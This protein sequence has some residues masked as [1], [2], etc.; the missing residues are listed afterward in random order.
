MIIADSG[1]VVLGALDFGEVAPG[2]EDVARVY[3][4]VPPAPEARQVEVQWTQIVPEQ[5]PT[6]DST[7]IPL[8][9]YY[10][11]GGSIPYL[12]YTCCIVAGDID[13]NGTL[14]I[15]DAVFRINWTFKGGPAPACCDAADANYN[16]AVG[17]DDAVYIINHIFKGGPG[18]V[19]GSAGSGPCPP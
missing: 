8:I 7:V 16:G 9:A 10:C 5:S 18:P 11:G 3:L 15:A 6:D 12:D 17:I 14:N 2:E 4:T 13:Y 1:I 19:C